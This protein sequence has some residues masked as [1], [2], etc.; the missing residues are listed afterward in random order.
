MKVIVYVKQDDDPAP[1]ETAWAGTTEQLG[2]QIPRT[3]ELIFPP[4]TSHRPAMVYSVRWFLGIDPFVDIYTTD[5]GE[6]EAL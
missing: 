6:E 2:G 1:G 3:G 4:G 5:L